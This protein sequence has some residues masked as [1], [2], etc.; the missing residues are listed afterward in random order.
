MSKY[1]VQVCMT[2]IQIVEVEAET[3]ESAEYMAFYAFDL[4]NAQRGEGECY[5]VSIDGETK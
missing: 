5:T 2:Y 4:D 1:T 3:Q